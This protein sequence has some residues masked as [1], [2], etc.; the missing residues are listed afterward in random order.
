M[1]NDQDVKKIAEAIKG[2][3]DETNRYTWSLH[4]EFTEWREIHTQH[5]EYIALEI[6]RRKRREDALMK[7]KN[8]FVGAIAIACVGGL[9]WIGKLILEALQKHHL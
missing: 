7:F 5:H 6:E 9:G 3:L 1:L 2:A 8:S 4:A